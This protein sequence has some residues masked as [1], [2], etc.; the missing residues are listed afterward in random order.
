MSRGSAEDD[1]KG[2]EDELRKSRRIAAD[3]PRRSW[4]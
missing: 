4:G 3:E 1:L 2:A